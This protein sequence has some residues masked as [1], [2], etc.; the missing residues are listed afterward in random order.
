MSKYKV[1]FKDISGS[2]QD[3][4]MDLILKRLGIVLVEENDYGSLGFEVMSEAE[5][6]KIE[7]ANNAEFKAWHDGLPK[8]K[9]KK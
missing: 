2:N 7:D 4:V 3:F 6:Q 8:K 5:W 9:K 1:D